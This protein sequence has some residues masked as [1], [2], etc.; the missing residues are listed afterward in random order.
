MSELPVA[1]P[2]AHRRQHA[3]LRLGIPA[4]LESLEGNEAVR[5][6]DLSQSGAHVVLTKPH[7]LRRAVLC[8]LEFEAFGF[9]AW[10]EGDHVGM[11]FE[12]LVPMEQL[13]E[14]RQRA[15]DVV[16]A[17]TIGD[18]AAARDFVAGTLHQGS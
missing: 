14:T 16:R 18:Y 12:E 17:E 6:I 10:R 1:K 7:D 8:W 9:V 4:R 15:P 2:E 3:R 13:F 11:E 5:L